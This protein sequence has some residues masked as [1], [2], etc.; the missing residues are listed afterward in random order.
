[1]IDLLNV[2]LFQVNGVDPEIGVKSL[3]YSRRGINFGKTVLVSHYRPDNITDDI[4]FHLMDKLDHSRTSKIHFEELTTYCDTEYMLFI[5][6]DGFVINPHLWNDEFFNYDYIGAP[7]PALPWNTVNRVGN[8][9]F[10]LESKKL[11]DLCTTIPWRGEHDDVLV[12]NTYRNYLESHGCRFPD[13]YLAAQFSL[14]HAIP[15]V[16]YS[17]DNCFG[18]HGKLTEESRQFVNMIKT[19]DINSEIEI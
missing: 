8:G 12:T 16:P 19:Y 17:L 2:T 1:M 5:Q 3:Q 11:L 18:F 6:S 15:E 9:G 14:E 7:W 13:I 4:E 10:R